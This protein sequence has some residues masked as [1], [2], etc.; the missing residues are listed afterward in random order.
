MSW[1]SAVDPP[2]LPALEGDLTGPVNAVAP[3]AVRNE[4]FTRVLA[5]C[6]T[7]RR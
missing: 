6:C 1:I 5:R 2:G 7:A 4:E 3:G